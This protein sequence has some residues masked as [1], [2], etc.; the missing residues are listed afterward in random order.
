MAAG[1]GI[2]ADGQGFGGS[3]EA[4]GGPG[5]AN[6]GAGTI[7][8]KGE[9]S[10]TAQLRVDNGGLPASTNTPLLS[11]SSAIDLV[12]VGGA[13]ADPFSGA[14][15]SLRSLELGSNSWLSYP[16]PNTGQPLTLTVSNN[17]I[18]ETGGGILLDGLGFAAGEG[19]GAGETS[20]SLSSPF[21]VWSGTG[22]GNGIGGLGNGPGGAGG[23]ALSLSVGGSL[24]LD[25]IIS[26][27]GT[28]GVGQGSGGGSGGSIRLTA[29][30]LAGGGVISANGGSGD[31][32]YGGGGGGGRI[33]LLS[34]IGT[35]AFEGFKGN[36]RARGGAG[37]T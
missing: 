11:V 31:P 14:S 22:G 2:L 34:G 4:H 10:S 32:P 28:A 21:L 9:P 26:A 7:Y 20:E 19:P 8:R 24:V 5:A 12:V 35:A 18:I 13:R 1:G 27:D 25:G 30:S 29:G 15:A 6:G 36:L 33:A 37:A 23:A 16:L 17:A 3:L